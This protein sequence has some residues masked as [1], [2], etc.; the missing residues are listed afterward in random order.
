[1]RFA[2]VI[3]TPE[4][5]AADITVLYGLTHQPHGFLKLVLSRESFCKLRKV[6]FRAVNFLATTDVMH[7]QLRPCTVAQRLNVV[8]S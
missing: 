1:M 5:P 7:V 8:C 2:P 3:C 4:K 6:T